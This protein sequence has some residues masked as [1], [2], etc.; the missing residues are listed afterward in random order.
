MSHFTKDDA[1][2]IDF[3]LLKVAFLPQA[4]SQQNT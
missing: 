1:A 4:K 3:S 2:V